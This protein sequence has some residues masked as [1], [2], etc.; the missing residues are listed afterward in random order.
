MYNKIREKTY[1]L[2]KPFDKK[3]KRGPKFK[4]SPEEY[5]AYE[6]Y[7]IVSS[8]STFRDME[9]DS[10]LF[11]DK[12]IDHGTFHHNFTKIPYEYLNSLLREIAKML[13]K[14]LGYFVATIFDSTGLNTRQYENTMFKGKI[15]RRSK[16]YKLHTLIAYH[17]KEKLTYYI[18]ALSS[19]KHI[20][21]AEG[22]ARLIRKNETHGFHLGDRAYDAEKVYKE[23][24]AK[25]R[26]PIIKP[27]VHKAK[28]S[29][30]KSKGRKMYRSHI[31][32]EL[33]GV[34]ET[35]YGGLENSGQT[36]TRCI[37][38]D[39]IKKK[40]MLAAVRHTFLTYLKVLASQIDQLT[41]IIRQ[42][43][44]NRSVSNK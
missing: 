40:G 6:A 43:L 15:R 38:D 9:L 13:E 44:K 10:K 7:K 39:S 19:D 23:I 26:V 35:S 1:K 20:S 18:D 2:G 4:I 3:G 32:K 34:I 29:S 16:D 11:V 8:N 42:T 30:E 24:L 5:A 31:Y 28:M 12:H 33:R 25:E 17:P 27:K 36:Y 22:A 37:N 14:L 21:D 41:G